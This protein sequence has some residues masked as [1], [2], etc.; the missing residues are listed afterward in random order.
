MKIIIIIDPS[1][2]R[3]TENKYGDNLWCGCFS[4]NYPRGLILKTFAF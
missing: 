1:K 3:C 4:E 2:E